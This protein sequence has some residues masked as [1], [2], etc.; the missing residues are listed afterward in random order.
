MLSWQNAVLANSTWLYSGRDRPDNEVD[1]LA[2][3]LPAS[4]V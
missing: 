4:L 2:I 1:D 3:G